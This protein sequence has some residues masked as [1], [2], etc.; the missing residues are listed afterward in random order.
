MII[1]YVSK[2]QLVEGR[3]Y[4]IWDREKLWKEKA[5]QNLHKAFYA[6]AV[7]HNIQHKASTK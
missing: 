1:V 5:Q 7:I 2:K 4:K 3:S 6:T